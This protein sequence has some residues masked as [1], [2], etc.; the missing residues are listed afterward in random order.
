MKSSRKWK[1]RKLRNI[2]ESR[3][4]Q[5]KIDNEKDNI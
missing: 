3:A 2:P 4:K 5:N 1:Q